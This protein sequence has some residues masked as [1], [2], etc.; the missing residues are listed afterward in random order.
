MQRTAKWRQRS[1][2]RRNGWWC[3]SSRLQVEL[4]EDRTLLSVNIWSSWATPTNVDSADTSAVEVGVKFLS[5][6]A[7]Q[8][9][10]IRFYKSAANT[11][12]H[13]G[14][15]WSSTGTLLASAIFTSETAFGWQQVNF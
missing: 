10:S 8:I 14:N 11:G 15:L 9:S 6:L 3:R 2:A 1:E 5:D 13:V 7:G 4:L 12:V